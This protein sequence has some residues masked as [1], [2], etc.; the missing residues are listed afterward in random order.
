MYKRAVVSYFN[1]MLFPLRKLSKSGNVL[2]GEYDLPSGRDQY[3]RR[4]RR[5]ALVASGWNEETQRNHKNHK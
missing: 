3:P 5:G 4:L 2:V 1:V